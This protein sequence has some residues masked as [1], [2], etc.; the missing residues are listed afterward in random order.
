MRPYDLG[1][2]WKPKHPSLVTAQLG[3]LYYQQQ[4][5]TEPMPDDSMYCSEEFDTLTFKHQRP[6]FHYNMMDMQLRRRALEKQPSKEEA[7]FVEAD[8]GTDQVCLLKSLKDAH[9]R[10]NLL[11]HYYLHSEHQGTLLRVSRHWLSQCCR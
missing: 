3:V 5:Q 10:V 11:F 1:Q 8:L 4:K 6:N 7:F 2:N 9:I